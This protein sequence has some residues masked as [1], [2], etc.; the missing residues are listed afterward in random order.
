[1]PAALP[2][3]HTAQVSHSPRDAGAE[4]SGLLAGRG[5]RP[6]HGGVTAPSH[7]PHS[8]REER[9]PQLAGAPRRT[10]ADG[11][12]SA[13]PYPVLHF[14]GR[15]PEVPAGCQRPSAKPAELSSCGNGGSPARC[16]SGLAAG[17]VV[18]CPSEGLGLKVPFIC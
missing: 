6:E 15:S 13:L 16:P 9:L 1:M 2:L 8:P 7:P 11:L 5:E 17:C 4:G 3:P 12:D 10:G 14:P 18:V